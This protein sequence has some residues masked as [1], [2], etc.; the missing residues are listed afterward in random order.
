MNTYDEAIELEE[1]DSRLIKE[2]DFTTEVYK[3]AGNKYDFTVNGWTMIGNKLGVSIPEIVRTETDKFHRVDARGTIIVDGREISRWGGHEQPKL[4]KVKGK[5]QEDQWAYTQALVKAQRNAYKA[6]A[7]SDESITQ[8]RLKEM[9]DAQQRKPASQ[10]GKPDAYKNSPE[11][12]TSDDPLTVA[13]KKMFANYNEAKGALEARIITEDVFRK[14]LYD[15]FK[16]KSRKQ[17]ASHQYEEATAELKK[18]KSLFAKGDSIDDSWIWKLAQP[19]ITEAKAAESVDGDALPFEEDLPDSE[20]S[21]WTIETLKEHG[22][23][24][25]EKKEAHLTEKGI[26][27]A[28]LHNGALKYFGVEKF[29]KKEWILFTDALEHDALPS[30]IENLSVKE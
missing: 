1:E 11:P 2:G 26:D 6:H 16:V 23:R 18:V 19:H 22:K 29:G 28:M 14:V 3:I 9:F 27:K 30:W 7:R 5:E 13:R 15:R 24:C 10:P 17:M 25:F 20:K 12:T 21:G 4:E 8:E